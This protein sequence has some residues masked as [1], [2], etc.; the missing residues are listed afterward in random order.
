MPTIDTLNDLLKH[1]L[2]DLFSAETQIIEALPAMIEAASAKE[3][4][5]ALQQHLAVTREQKKRLEKIQDLLG[6]EKL[7]PE[8]RGFFANLFK[9]DEGEQ[10]CKAMEGLLKEGDALL[11]EDMTAEVMD[12]AIIAAAQ[13]VEHYEIS[14]YG[15]ARAFALQLKLNQVAG[16]LEQTLNEEYEA[17]DSLT[18]LA[19]SKVNLE[20]GAE[21]VPHKAA[22]PPAKKSTEKT[23]KKASPKK[24]KAANA[25]K[26]AAAKKASGKSQPK[27]QKSR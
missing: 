24:A 4:K 1:E 11:K 7:A 25:K 23:P 27:K 8:K 10:H 13:K 6:E 3:L 16:L 12:A 19:L 20:A 17:D 22:K 5:K 2:K 14:S 15:T 26:S 9:S 21:I 18:A